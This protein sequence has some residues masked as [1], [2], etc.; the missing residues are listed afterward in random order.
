MK[1]NMNAIKEKVILQNTAETANFGL[2]TG[3]LLIAFNLLD[4]NNMLINKRT[5]GQYQSKLPIK[6]FC[7]ECI[8]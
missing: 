7:N 2:L 5:H 1:L 8:L 4:F 6:L 3:T